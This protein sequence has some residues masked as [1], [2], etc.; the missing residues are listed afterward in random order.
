VDQFNVTAKLWPSGDSFDDT[1]DTNLVTVPSSFTRHAKDFESSADGTQ[2]YQ[3]LFWNTGRHVTNK[4]HVRWNFSVGGWGLWT[5]TKWYGTPPP[6]GPGGA[7]RVRVDPF[8]IGGNAAITGSGTAI[9]SAASTYAS[10][11][12]PFGGDDHEIGTANGAVDTVAKDP[13]T[14]LQFAG[15]VQ[16]IWGGD[17]TGEFVETDTGSAPGSAG[18]YPS[19]TGPFH[20][21]KGGSADLLALYGNSARSRFT[22]NLAD[23]LAELAVGLPY[24]PVDP[25]P[26]DRIRLAILE[27]ILQKSKPSQRVATEFQQVLDAA[28]RMN[29]EEL[30]MAVKS[31]Q[32]T[33]NLGQTAIAAVQALLKKAKK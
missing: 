12:Y 27:E 3:F 5:A 8:T 9:D 10:G 29:A 16:L 22:A 32:S 11:A 7:K 17:D 30:K 2:Q 6:P 13:F 24:S 25:S 33:V 15:W 19:G 18:F 1:I 28:P 23:L 21:D 14:L 31:L 20:V 26:E 4:R